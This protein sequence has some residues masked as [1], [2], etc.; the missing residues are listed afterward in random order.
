MNYTIN[1]QPKEVKVLSVYTLGTPHHG[2]IVS[3]IIVAGRTTTDPESTDPDIE[4]LMSHD[5]SFLSTPQPPAI[6]DQ[7]T[8]SMARFNASFPSIPSEVRFYNYG[9]DA[10]LNNNGAISA[11]EARPLLES[12]VVPDSTL[13]AAANAMYNAIGRIATISI[14]PGA[15]GPWGVN[16]FTSIEVANTNTPFHEN[17]LVTSVPSSQAPGGTYLGTR[18]ANH[19]SIKSPALAQQ[20]LDRINADYPNR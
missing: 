14:T 8:A 11:A 6:N 3:D 10:D 9:A 1:Y 12:S 2:T 7:M 16:K 20:I 18:D 5:Y 4:Y 19:S 13:A 17:D 15:R